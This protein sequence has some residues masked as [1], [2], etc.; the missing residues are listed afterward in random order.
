MVSIRWPP[1]L[2][3]SPHTTSVKSRCLARSWTGYLLFLGS[4][5]IC[6]K[7][8]VGRRRGAFEFKQRV[9]GAVSAVL[10]GA[11]TGDDGLGVTTLACVMGGPVPKTRITGPAR[12][13]AAL[14]KRNDTNPNG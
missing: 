1:A 13:T 12:A 9:S 8:R 10:I 5:V 6:E 4:M 3:C 11:S 2:W 7:P 14:P